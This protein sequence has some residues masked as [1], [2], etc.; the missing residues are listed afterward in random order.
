MRAAALRRPTRVA[1]VSAPSSS[2]TTVFAISGISATGTSCWRL[3]ECFPFRSRSFFSGAA[4]SPRELTAYEFT[5]TL[6]NETAEP[7]VREVAAP[8]QR[9]VIAALYEAVRT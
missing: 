4:V 2:S 7:A 6:T 9:D 5:S 1:L 8:A 3:P